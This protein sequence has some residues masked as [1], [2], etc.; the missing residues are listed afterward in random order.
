MLDFNEASSS[1]NKD[2]ELEDNLDDNS[3]NNQEEEQDEDIEEEEEEEYEE[4]PNSPITKITTCSNINSYSNFSDGVN[5]QKTKK[6]AVNQNPPAEVTNQQNEVE[7]DEVS[8]LNSPELGKKRLL[9]NLDDC[10][11]KLSQKENKTNK[12]IKQD[13]TQLQ[14]HKSKDVNPAAIKEKKEK[15]ANDQKNKRAERLASRGTPQQVDNQQNQKQKPMQKQQ[16]Q[17]AKLDFVVNNDMNGSN[18]TPHPQ[19]PNVIVNANKIVTESIFSLSQDIRNK[20]TYTNQTDFEFRLTQN[21]LD[22]KGKLT[23]NKVFFLL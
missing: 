8:E 22:F 10:N 18:M 9:K 20:V 6:S 21:S 11:E 19:G 15:L 13:L 4:I 1:E 23:P 7:N 3:N 16:I 5:H 17:K 2:N 12:A 14:N